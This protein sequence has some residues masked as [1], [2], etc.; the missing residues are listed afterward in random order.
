MKEKSER[1]VLVSA[2]L[3]GRACRYDGQ[4][5]KDLVL[6][7]ELT[8]R[9]MTPV[10]FCPEEHGQLGT[11][12]PPAWIKT[13]DAQA[14]ISGGSAVVDENGRDVT[15]NFLVGAQGAVECCQ[16]HGIQA[17]FLK[18]GSPSCGVRQ[19]HVGG[20]RVEGPGVTTAALEQAGVTCEGVP[21]GRLP[22]GAD[23]AG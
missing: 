2:C 16:T 11:P 9:G 7:E 12:R 20:V 22:G 17:A 8:L 13:G 1:P 3:L 10:P 21:G 4:N 18:E 5:S 6:E 14:V 19:T 15:Q 23:P